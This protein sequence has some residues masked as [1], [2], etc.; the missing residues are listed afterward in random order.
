[1]IWSEVDE[2]DLNSAGIHWK[3][4]FYLCYCDGYC[5]SAIWVVPAEMSCSLGQ[6]VDRLVGGR[7]RSSAP[8]RQQRD[9]S[10]LLAIGYCKME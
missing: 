9:L 10:H 4:Y 7:S 3:V 2:N 8:C 6:Q 5:G 1:M